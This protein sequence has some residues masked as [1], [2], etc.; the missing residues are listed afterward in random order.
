MM[1]V[2]NSP[3]K[4]HGGKSYVAK[5]IN[6]LAAPHL[7]WVEVFGGGLSVTLAKDPTDVSEV[8]NDIYGQLTNFWIT[9][10]TP[11][12]F[13]NFL[14]RAE[15]TPFSQPEYD[16]AAAMNSTM[17]TTTMTADEQVERAVAFFIAA[18]QSRAGRFSEFATVSRNRTRR[19]RNE[20]V[21]AWQTSVE[22][23]ASVHARLGRVL[24]LCQPALEVIKSQDGPNTLFYCDPPYLPAARVSPD[25][26]HHEMTRMDHARLL[27]A[28][29]KIQGKFMLSGYASD[30]YLLA[31]KKYG[32][33]RHQQQVANHAAGGAK[34]RV[35]TEC[36]WANYETTI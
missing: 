5:W 6:G 31:E 16:A 22:G 23:L 14:R 10:Q 13:E 29:S 34:K 27:V 7:H 2:V 26:Y 17:M 1:M 9:L 19:G 8:V 25:V 32:W 30:L 24:I 35:M 15:A 21:S 11:E 20:Q 12:L 33:K 36:L 18:R 28:L 4:Y 3:I